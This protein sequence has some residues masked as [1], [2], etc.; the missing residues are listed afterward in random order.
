MAR[1]GKMVM[2]RDVPARMRDGVTLPADVYTPEGDGP[3]PVLLMRTPYDK[4][5]AQDSVYAHPRW[6]ARRGYIVVIQDVRGR[7]SGEGEWYPF[8]HETDDGYDTVEWAARLPK[9][10]GKVGMYGLSYVGATQMLASVGAPPHL[11]CIAPGM[12]SSE[13]YDGWT[14]RGGAL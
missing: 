13:Y 8:A 11:A 7:W 1:S 3:F 9:S 5:S 12:T 6:Y 2:T 14:Y 10:N 4:T